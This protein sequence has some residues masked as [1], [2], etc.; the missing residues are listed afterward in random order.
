LPGSKRYES[1]GAVEGGA[2]GDEDGDE[3]EKEEGETE[4]VGRVLADL[5]RNMS[6]VEVI[7]APPTQY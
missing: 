6:P 5:P 2:D 7:D 3:E 1:E 4:Q